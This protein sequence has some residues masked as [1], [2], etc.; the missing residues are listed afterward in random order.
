[1]GLKRCHWYVSHALTHFLR[2]ETAAGE[3]YLTQILRGLHQVALEGGGWDTA[4]LL[5]P[6]HDPCSREPY[7]CTEE[8]LHTIAAYRDAERRI[9]GNNRFRGKGGEKGETGE[10]ST[11]Q[12]GH[13][14]GDKKQP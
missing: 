14:K 10:D 7:G 8:D 1:M 11:K 5:L 12:K 6:G 2:G 13:K 9:Q 4:C 3:A